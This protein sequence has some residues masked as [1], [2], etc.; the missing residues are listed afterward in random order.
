MTSNLE[1][2][3]TELN[4]LEVL[5]DFQLDQKANYLAAFTSKDPTDKISYLEKWTKLLS[6]TSINSKTIFIKNKIVGSIAKYEIDGVAEITYWIGKEFWRKGIAS[7]A[8]CLFLEIE[9]KRPINGRVAFDNFG[10]IKVL[11][12]NGFK[13]IG[14]E[15][16]FSNSRNMEIDEIIYQLK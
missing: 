14:I 12:I 4:D 15:K 3:N 16:G 11:E 1:L 2:K 5:F 8:L 6:N 7:N 13:Q 10:S 9:K